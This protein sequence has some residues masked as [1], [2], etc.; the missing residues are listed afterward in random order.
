M[1]L[2]P[3]SGIGPL[4]TLTLGMLGLG[5][6]HV[7]E[8]VKGAPEGNAPYMTLWGG[9]RPKSCRRY[10]ENDITTQPAWLV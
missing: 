2:L 8:R 9:T 10:V 1:N 4:A 6:L 7:S 5:G 3:L